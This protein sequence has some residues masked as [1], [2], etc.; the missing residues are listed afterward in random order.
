[1]GASFHMLTD[2]RSIRAWP[3]PFYDCHGLEH[4][5]VSFG[6]R[7]LFLIWLVRWQLL[8]V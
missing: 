8:F 1:M 4:G 5:I 2:A 3:Y 7:W 6:L